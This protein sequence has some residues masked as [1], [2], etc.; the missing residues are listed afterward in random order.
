MDLIFNN[1]ISIFEDILY[2]Y[3][4]PKQCT[5][6]YTSNLILYNIYLNNNYFDD[7]Y[8]I[9]NNRHKL[10][11]AVNIWCDNREE[12]ILKYGHISYWNTIYITDMNNL[13][14]WKRNFNDDISDWN[15]SNVEIMDGMFIN[16]NFNQDLNQWNIDKL[17]NSRCIFGYDFN[18]LNISNWT[19]KNN[20]EYICQC[21]KY[22]I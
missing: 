3:L 16:T 4:T 20:N 19:I 21:H 2:K 6:L 13:F 8:F 11:T 18:I 17:E 12:A 22:N 1:Q 9:P 10:K 15:T 14:S 5:K 7:Y